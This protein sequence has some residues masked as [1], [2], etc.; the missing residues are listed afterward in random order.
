[1]ATERTYVIPLRREFL[2]APLYRRTKKATTALKEFLTKHM[3]SQDVRLGRDLNEFIWKHGI[4]NPPSRVKV[5]V[6]KDDKGVVK[7]ELFG[8]KYQEM[9]KEDREN[10]QKE[11]EKKET[12]KQEKKTEAKEV[13]KPKK[14]IKSKAKVEQKQEEKVASE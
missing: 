5:T 8:S 4:Q 13:E 2:K 14:E 10:L 3:K 11:T 7:A 12:K 6:T 9:T 1:M